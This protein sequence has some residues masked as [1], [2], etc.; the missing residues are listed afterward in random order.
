MA[1]NGNIDMA[2]EVAVLGVTYRVLLSS[3]V[4]GSV[5]A[6]LG[7]GR[8]WE[9]ALRGIVGATTALIGHHVTAQILVSLLDIPFGPPNLPSVPD[10]EPVA[11]FVVGL[12]GM[13]LCQAAINTARVARDTLPEVVE[14]KLG[15][16]AEAAKLPERFNEPLKKSAKKA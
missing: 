2:H 9:K 10:M 7:S 11:A 5:S 12:V 14:D 6:V 16:D 8:L 3:L 4:G 15:H 1:A 13:M